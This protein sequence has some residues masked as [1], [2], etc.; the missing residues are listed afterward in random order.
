[1]TNLPISLEQATSSTLERT[2]QESV[3]AL[4]RMISLG[5]PKV[6][7]TGAAGLWTRTVSHLL[8]LLPKERRA[9][10]I[11]RLNDTGYGDYI[12]PSLSVFGQN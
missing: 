4:E 8:N 9:G 6:E 11:Q 3:A 7:E 1:M 2:E 10:Y 12:L 5:A